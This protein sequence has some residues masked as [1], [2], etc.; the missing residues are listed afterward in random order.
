MAY[1]TDDT[2]RG[3]KLTSTPTTLVVASD[4]T[5]EQSWLGKW[6]AQTTGSANAALG[7]NLQTRSLLLLNQ[8]HKRS[9]VR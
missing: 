2:L 7:L 8:S 9:Y 6:N 5:V 4:G 1:V 3:Y